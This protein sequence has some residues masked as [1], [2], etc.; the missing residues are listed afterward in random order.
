MATNSVNDG[1]IIGVINGRL[2]KC[3]RCGTRTR[4]IDIISMTLPQGVT[5]KATILQVRNVDE[6][7][8]IGNVGIGCGCYAR[9]HRQITHI[10]RS[11]LNSGHTVY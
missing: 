1:Y 4:V 3:G 8:A 11:R 5:V 9:F 10:M 2:K 7:T 6:P